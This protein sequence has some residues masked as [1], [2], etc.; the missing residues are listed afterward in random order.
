[1]GLIQKY[2]D[3]V[4]SR[5]KSKIKK[6][7]VVIKNPKATKE[8]RDAAIQFF[9][10][11]DDSYLAVSSLL[12]RFDYSLDHGINDSREKDKTMK[13]IV[14]FG[15]KAVTP[16]L[17]HL[18]KSTKIA[19]P[20][21]ILTALTDSARVVHALESSLSFGDIDFDQDVVNKN[22]DILCCLR[23][24]KL[25]DQGKRLFEFLEAHDE[26]LRYAAVEVLLHQN[27]EENYKALEKFLLDNSA[28]NI[29][30]KQ[31]VARKFIDLNR[32]LS[33]T[34]DFKVGFMHPDL[35]VK[36]DYTLKYA[37]SEES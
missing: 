1:M 21:K 29:R 10:G 8:D 5:K 23:D 6:S 37:D 34:S 22:Y 31:S 7:L 14:D 30:V 4:E 36:K 9:A 26:R 17:D 19:W 2:R 28:E 18:K 33:H 11:L 20:L 27:S 3:F 16:V 32:K 15:E 13:A 25:S 24:Y 35:V 12:G